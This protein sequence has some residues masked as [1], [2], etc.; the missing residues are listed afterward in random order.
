MTGEELR[1]RVRELQDQIL[2]FRMNVV[3]GVVDNV[4][5]AR[6]ARRDIARINTVLRE[7][8]LAQEQGKK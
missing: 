1:N 5:G 6:Q 7:R 2:M 8:E 3:T 4:R